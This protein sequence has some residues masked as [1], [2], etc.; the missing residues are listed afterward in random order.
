MRG[1]VSQKRRALWARGF[2]AVC[3]LVAVLVAARVW[4][5][6]A[7]SFVYVTNAQSN[8][9]SLIDTATNTV[10]ATVPVA[11]TFGV[12][13]AGVA[14]TPMENKPMSRD[15]SR[16]LSLSSIRPAKKWWPRSGWE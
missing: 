3:A 5:T 2:A 10:V 11:K 4:L 15:I 1:N 13:V 8:T 9:L 16:T 6:K 12:A 14:V 7:A